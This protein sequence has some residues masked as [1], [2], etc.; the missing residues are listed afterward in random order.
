MRFLRS[1]VLVAVGWLALSPGFAHATRFA[2]RADGTGDAPTIQAAI[3]LAATGDSVMLDPGTY[4]GAGNR[5]ISYHGKGVTVMSSAG[6]DVTIIDCQGL[7]RGFIFNT[8]EPYSALLQD[9]TIENGSATQ[10]GGIYVSNLAHTLVQHCVIR[11]CHATRGG[12][13]YC[14]DQSANT[15]RDNLIEGNT[16]SYGGGI[17]DDQFCFSFF[18]NNTIQDN[19]ATIEGGGFYS[20]NDTGDTFLTDNVIDGNSAPKGGG[21]AARGFFLDVSGGRITDNSG[22]GAGIYVNAGRGNFES[23]VIAGNHGAG[24]HLGD[25]AWLTNCTIVGNGFYGVT[26]EN[27][28]PRL[29]R[30][31]VAFNVS[32][33]I[34]CTGSFKA[35]L[36]CCD[37]VSGSYCAQS[38]T[39]FISADPLFCTTTGDNAYQL[40][41]NSPC[42]PAASPC[43]QLIGALPVGC[44]AIPVYSFLECPP[45]TMVVQGDVFTLVTLGAFRITNQSQVPGTFHYSITTA[46]AAVLLNGGDL[47]AL[48]GD[49]PL[50]GPGETFAPP[51]AQMLAGASAPFFQDVVCHVTSAAPALDETC[52]M[53]VTFQ[54]PVPVAVSDMRGRV[55]GHQV[56]LT[57]VSH[58]GD[59]VTGIVVKRKS[60]S[61]KMP[62]VAVAELQ[63][64]AV[65]FVDTGV[66]P[67]ETVEYNLDVVGNG[68]L[69][70]ASAPVRVHMPAL[71]LA[72]T[73]ISPNPFRGS[74]RIAFDIPAADRVTVE[75][76]DVRGRRVR[77]LAN[78]FMTAGSHEIL[79]GTHGD[80]P[81][82]SGVYFLRLSQGKDVV[83][84]KVT[85]VQ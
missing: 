57:W 30:C 33:A 35:I 56:R 17:S 78:Q 6:R 75:I 58:F 71:A 54:Q 60:I 31:I 45:D 69:L 52:S 2:V 5:D 28:R 51:Q 77:T 29:T 76:F 47:T 46:G 74:A 59:E 37:V 62:A 48:D 68:E 80:G 67:G 25:D 23:I 19:T 64:D 43:G 66:R 20:E 9:L 40:A 63:R 11:A 82:P 12:G 83:T 21:I 10:G 22:L 24:A 32:D 81:L 41:A 15:I 26:V 18:E 27:A 8:N 55:E 85:L 44:D 84:A 39:N 3:D 50:L 34:Y 1:G 70:T 38:N 13:I 49:T 79:W 4:V 61:S 72:V 36:D 65:E 42:A 53:R 14:G 73:S 16:A 7:G